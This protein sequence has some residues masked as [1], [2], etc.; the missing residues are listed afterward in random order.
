MSSAQNPAV[1]VLA[2]GAQSGIGLPLRLVLAALP[3]M[4][5]PLM[6][7]PLFGIGA[8]RVANIILALACF[9]FVKGI[10]D[11]AKLPNLD[12]IQKRALWFFGV[13]LLLFVV[14]FVRSIPNLPQFVALFPTMF[15]IDVISYVD[16]ELIVP[17]FYAFVFVYVLVLIRSQEDLLET[18]AAIA[19]GVVIQALVVVYCFIENPQ[20]LSGDDRFGI[21]GITDQVLAMHYNDV[22]ATYIITGPLLLYFALK[23]GGGWMVAYV[24]SIV[25]VLLLESRT[26]IFVFAAMSFLTLLAA[27]GARFSM[28]WIVAAVGGCVGALGNILAKL[29]STGISGRYGFSLYLLLSGRLEKIWTP[30]LMEWLSSAQLFWFG[31]GEYGM[32]TSRMLASGLM[33]FVAEAHNAF[34][35][36]F[37]DDGIVLFV[38]FTAILLFLLFMG[39]RQG[40]RLRSGLYWSLFLC[41]VGFLASCF[42]GRRF[43]PHPENAMIFPIL[44]A[45]LG[46]ARL[47]LA[48]MQATAR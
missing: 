28:W 18:F 37:L 38:L 8:L 4:P 22:A 19:A 27:G 15:S 9:S 16:Y 23:R 36:F 47:T 45:L 20:I 44:A 42:S 39:W 25:A 31:A 17:L 6:Q 3:V 10:V 29:L 46:A 43:F 33:L 48:K 5:S 12:T 14:A 24:L 41:I 1:S 34:L 30:L 32:L 35:E 21:S 40:R 7:A 26:G 11:S 2:K 13:Y